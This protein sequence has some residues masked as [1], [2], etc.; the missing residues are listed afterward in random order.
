MIETIL[1]VIAI[2][3][4]CVVSVMISRLKELERKIDIVSEDC[5]EVELET[6]KNFYLITDY[7]DVHTEA[8]AELVD[9]I[10]GE[11]A[12]KVERLVKNKRK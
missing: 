4:F 12:L 7:L 9:D 6:Y 1:V 11:I 3:V 2:F 10:H 8:S 5:L